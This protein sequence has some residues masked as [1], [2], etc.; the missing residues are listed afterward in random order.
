MP[1]I[2]IVLFEDNPIDSLTVQMML[3]EPAVD[4][5][6]FHLLG[7]FETVSSLLLF[8][9]NNE[10]D[11]LIAD[12]F[13]NNK[14][15]GLTLIDHLKHRPVSILFISNTHDKEIF[16]KVQRKPLLRFISKPIQLFT[17]HSTLCSIYE[18]K[19][20]N[21]QY[22]FKDRRYLYLSGKG[23]QREQVVFDDIMYLESEGNYSFIHTLSKKYVI[24]KSLSQLIIDELTDDF[25]RVHKK[26]IVNK[27]YIKKIDETTIRLTDQLSLP[28]GK[29]YRKSLGDFVKKH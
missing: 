29:S 25:L 20:R 10:V 8:L 26:F 12:I 16:A 14:P 6:Q 24:K 11:I 19:Q 1:L 17:L 13:T 21:K 15:V 9:E 3:A 7:V 22:Q 23:G 27:I 18:E 4:A 5:F 28:I 2:R